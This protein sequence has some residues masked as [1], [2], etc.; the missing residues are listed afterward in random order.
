M[1]DVSGLKEIIFTLFSFYIFVFMVLI[2]LACLSYVGII[3][4]AITFDTCINYILFFM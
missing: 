1:N 2:V 4:P 3:E